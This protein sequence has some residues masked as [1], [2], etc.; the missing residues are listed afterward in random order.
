M[1]EVSA[2]IAK[3]Q[4]GDKAARE[5]LI[6]NNLGLVHAVVRRFYGR[7]IEAEDLFQIGVIGLMKAIDKFDLSFQVKFST[8]A[9]PLISGEIKR[10]LR[11][12]G[13]VK[14]SRTVKENSWKVNKAAA[15]LQNTLGRDPTIQE[16]A[17]EAE[18]TAEEVVEEEA[19]AE[20][21]VAQETVAE[22]TVAEE[23]VAE[24]AVAEE[25]VTEE[26]VEEPVEEEPKKEFNTSILIIFP[27]A[28]VAI[29]GGYIFM[30]KKKNQPKR[31]AVDPDADYIE[32]E[33]D[34][35]AD[36]L[37]DEDETIEGEEE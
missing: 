15:Y 11:D 5:M 12:D 20:E 30:K 19:A 7:G 17:K 32:D 18:L 21:T 28:G 26:K 3:S 4:T 29:I 35:L 33:D 16:I 10:F 23:A 14:I 2:L 31:P 36:I 27:I 1:E 6:E 25:P 13:P 37:E 8:Y 34:Y 22:E 9:V 24:E